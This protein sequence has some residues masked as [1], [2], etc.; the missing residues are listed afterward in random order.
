[1]EDAKGTDP[2]PLPPGGGAGQQN[3]GGAAGEV[4]AGI[5]VPTL[6]LADGVVPA[7]PGDAELLLVALGRVGHV[8]LLGGHLGEGED[9]V[10]EAMDDLEARRR[11]GV[12][13]AQ[14]A[15]VAGADD[16]AGDGVPIVGQDDVADFKDFEPRRERG[17]LVV[18]EG[19]EE[20][21]EE[22]GADHLVLDVGGVGQADGGGNLPAQGREV[23]PD[24]AKAVGEDL[25]VP[26]AADLV[27]EEVA[28]LVERL[29]PTDGV[30]VRHPLDDV[31]VPVGDAHVLGNV[32]GVQNVRSGGGD[33]DLE[34]PPAVGPLFE[35]GGSQLDLVAQL[36]HALGRL[37]DAN[38]GV[39]EVDAGLDAAGGQLGGHV[40]PGGGSGGVHVVDLDGLDLEGPGAV[41]GEH[42][43]DGVEDDVGLG[44]V[45]GGALD[46]D[47]LGVEGDLGL[48]PV[49]DGRQ[50]QDGVFVVEDDGVERRVLDDGHVRLEMLAIRMSLVVLQEGPA[51][52]GLA[53]GV[54]GRFEGDE[55]NFVGL[56][57]VVVEGSLDG[58]HVV[59][60]DGHQGPLPAEVAM[61]LILQIDEG[62]VPLGGEGD[63]PQNGTH[64]K[65]TD[66]R[67]SFLLDRHGF[68]LVGRRRFIHGCLHVAEENF[69]R[70]AQTLDAEQIVPVGRNVDLVN[71]GRAQ[72]LDLILGQLGRR[73]FQGLLPFGGNLVELHS[74]LEAKLVEGLVGVR[75]ADV[76]EEIV[77]IDR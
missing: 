60:A 15:L 18:L 1:M 54:V 66:R 73:G 13:G 25:G 49:D 43:N 30:G 32:H 22:G 7:L 26:R 69:E 29:L 31:V 10:D 75:S 16:G 4:G 17:T 11:P 51:G 61:E 5:V 23:V 50:R 57:G 33:A 42:G 6:Q 39:D 52:E 40:R 38:H 21:G 12:D 24:R 74:K 53:G 72:R 28:Q 8:L 58:I 45:G 34:H 47:V 2:H 64:D 3:L 46:E 76:R 70:P 63:V 14:P 36:D 48:V 55:L 20:A 27:A 65:G 9:A 41:L 44:E 62:G 77:A 68:H 37:L 56:A 67:G 19:L 35:G 71:D 59:R